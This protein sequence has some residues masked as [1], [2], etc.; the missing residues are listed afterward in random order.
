MNSKDQFLQLLGLARR[1]GNLVF[2]TGDTLTAIQKR[3]AKIAFFPVDGG[4]SQQKKFRDKA[5]FYHVTLVETFT[6]E[7]LSQAIGLNRSIMAVTDQGF[8]KKMKQLLE[9]KERN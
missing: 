9:E 8:A 4:A 2:G 6:K 3:K 7:E 1:S 5:N